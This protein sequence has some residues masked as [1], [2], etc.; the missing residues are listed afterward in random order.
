[1]PTGRAAFAS[2]LTL[3]LALAVFLPS[4]TVGASSDHASIHPLE[5]VE[6]VRP[7]PGAAF[8]SLRRPSEAFLSPPRGDGGWIPDAYI[9]V[10]QDSVHAELTAAEMARVHG[11]SVEHVYTVSLKGFAATMPAGALDSIDGDPRVR[12]VQPDRPIWPAAQVLPTGVDRVEADRNS[13]ARIDGRDER[14]DASVAPMITPIDLSHPDLNVV[15]GASFVPSEPTAD[16][17]VGHGTHVAGTAAALD[18]GIGVVGVAPGARLYALKVF[19]SEGQGTVSNLIA[20]V[21]WITENAAAIDVASLSLSG[22]APNADDGNCGGTK[23]DALH[24]AICRSVAAGV[25]YVVAAGN[26]KMNAADVFPAAYDE[27]LTVSALSDLDG[28]PLDDVITWFSNFGADVDLIA[29]GRDI[30]STFPGGTYGT[31]SGTSMATP[32]VSGAA[33]LYITSVRAQTGRRPSPAEV[34]AFL[35]AQG[36]PAPPGGWPGDSDGIPEPLV[37][38]RD[39]LAGPVDAEASLLIARPDRIEADAESLAT[40]QTLPRDADGNAIGPGLPVDFTATAGT[41]VGSAEDGGT[42]VYSQALASAPELLGTTARISATVD[43][44]RLTAT[45]EVVFTEDLLDGG[46]LPLVSSP[47]DELDV[48]IASNGQGYLVAWWGG[49]GGSFTVYASRFGLDGSPL[50]A[51]PIVLETGTRIGPNVDGPPP[52][53]HVSSDGKDYL[54]LWPGARDPFDPRGAIVRAADGAIAAAFS[55]A[56]SGSQYGPAASFGGSRYLAVWYEIDRSAARYDL[57]GAWITPDGAVTPSRGFPVIEGATPAVWIGEPPAV[58]FGGTSHLLAWSRLELGPCPGEPTQACVLDSDLWAVRVASS[59]AVLDPNGFP[60]SQRPRLERAPSAVSGGGETLVAWETVEED[61]MTGS[62]RSARVDAVRVRGDGTILDP[63]PIPLAGA[64]SFAFDPAVTFV[65]EGTYVVAWTN[66]THPDDWDVN[67]ARVQASGEVHDPEGFAISM[68][69]SDQ[70][71]VAIASSDSNVLAVF[72]DFAAYA[73]DRAD[74]TGQRLRGAVTNRPPSLG[75]VQV[76]PDPAIPGQEVTFRATA[77]DPDGDRLECTWAFGDGSSF[78]GTTAPGGGELTVAH[79]YVAVDVYEATLTLTDGKGG[80]A[81][82][83]TSVVIDLP[84][85]LRVTTAI[86]AHPTWGVQ[87]KILVDDIPRDEW[88]LAWLKIAP[89]MHSVAF[90]DVPNL[91]TPESASVTVVSGEIT[92]VQG[93]YTA[94]GWL[95]VV[96]DPP[97]PGTISVDGIPRNDWGVWL[98]L[99]PGTYRISFGAV[100]EYRPPEP[101]SVVVVAEELTT[102]VGRYT[103]DGTSPGSDPT[104]FG[105]LRVTTELSDGRPGVHAQILIDGIPRDEWGLSWLKL[106]PGTYTVSF[107]D[108]PNL[109]TPESISVSVAAGRITEA[110]GVFDVHGWLRVMTDP[111][112]PGTIFVDGIP[113]NDWGMWQSVPAGAYRVSFGPVPGYV[114]PP[115]QE[116]EVRPGALT[117]L[118]GF[119]MSL[120]QAE[121]APPG[122][123]EAS[124]GLLGG[125]ASHGTASL[126]IDGLAPAVPGKTQMPTLRTADVRLPAECRKAGV[127]PPRS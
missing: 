93:V 126:M 57:R 63:A 27:V 11:L 115:S 59:G 55:I 90:S 45:A 3:L 2:G 38:V 116:A 61:P 113:R 107:T 120:A 20:A 31:M 66:G 44:V 47:A 37:R 17:G 62:L 74:L 83:S 16:D 72:E 67:G 76:S 78:S 70:F 19:D 40:V 9:V 80:A 86:D 29:P 101:L 21:D 84:G 14:V 51:L 112:V 7:Y 1:M 53:P 12:Y 43:S 104:G 54:I 52:A 102:V 127:D 35:K 119:Y 89:G 87:G 121:N 123:Q 105:L 15:G 106:L 30:L 13:T 65:S 110:A 69:A 23:G 26:E 32:H 92:S 28:T 56:N 98:A 49:S 77:S 42:D 48:S 8:P 79:V 24:A 100:S 58:A 96:T 85:F 75:P 33:A 111:P 97:L 118:S 71:R 94:H 6:L 22:F 109:G 46:P 41:L 34:G 18:N 108:V 10:L 91:G 50:D 125:F 99:A 88:G 60:L 95:R 114:T 73:A 82:A 68:E 122:Q 117:T 25:T 81:S 64:P 36:E 4:G 124:D 103:F 39:L 5:T